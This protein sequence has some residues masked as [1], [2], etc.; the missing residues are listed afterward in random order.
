MQHLPVKQCMLFN[1][2]RSGH[3]NISKDGSII[4]NRNFNARYILTYQNEEGFSGP[5]IP[6]K[7]SCLSP[8][9][10]V[11]ASEMSS[12]FTDNPLEKS[13][14]PEF[15]KVR[16]FPIKK[17]DGQRNEEKS[18]IEVTRFI[19]LRFCSSLGA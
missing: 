6:P 16:D 9:I 5:H 15:P 14:L 10:D 12:H 8:T 4:E 2:N 19:I 3:P 18:T 13:S 7:A 11:H 17:S 1:E